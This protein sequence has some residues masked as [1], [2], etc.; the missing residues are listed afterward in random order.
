[1]HPPQ[2]ASLVPVADVLVT[3]SSHCTAPQRL[4]R[5]QLW[6]LWKVWSVSGWVAGSIHAGAACV[7]DMELDKAHPGDRGCVLM[8]CLVGS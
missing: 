3:R 5:S 4:P 6:P 8:A 1:M 2:R 7:R